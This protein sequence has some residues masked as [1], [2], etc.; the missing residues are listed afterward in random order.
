MCEILDSGNR[1]KFETGAVRDISEGKGRFDLMPLGVIANLCTVNEDIS[2]GAVYDCINEFVTSGDTEYLYRALLDLCSYFYKSSLY[3]MILSVSRHF[4]RGCKK[5]G[6]NNWMK[7][8][9]ANCY[10]D[11]A[12]RHFTKFIL[13]WDDEPH[14]DAAAWNILCCIWTCENK[15]ELNTYIRKTKEAKND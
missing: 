12:L 2:E 4:E 14:L 6:E 1:R 7:G 9:P 8:I 5:Y 15:P 10:I 13:G 3:S 11:S